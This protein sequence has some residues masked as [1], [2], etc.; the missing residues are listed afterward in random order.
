MHTSFSTLHGFNEALLRDTTFPASENSLSHGTVVAGVLRYFSAIGFSFVYDDDRLP[1]SLNEL[2]LP[3][4]VD[5][6]RNGSLL[7][8]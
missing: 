4:S 7:T 1:H 8:G 2:R 3:A 5:C 6:G